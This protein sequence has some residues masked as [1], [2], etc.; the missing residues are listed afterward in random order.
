MTGS[1]ECCVVRRA[2]GRGPGGE[3]PKSLQVGRR[4]RSIRRGRRL[5]E[6]GP[7]GGEPRFSTEQEQ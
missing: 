4:G 1:G 2:Q 3:L 5:L 7:S 6:E